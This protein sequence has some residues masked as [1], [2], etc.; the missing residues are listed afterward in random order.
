MT[1]RAG[2]TARLRCGAMEP[3]VGYESMRVELTDGVVLA[4]L[5]R[6]ERMNA[7]DGPLRRSVRRLIDEVRDNA[8]A[9]VL[10]L[11]GAGRG[12]CSGADLTAADRSHVPAAAHDPLFQWCVDLLEL[13][14]PTIAAINGVAAGGGLGMALCCDIRI[15]STDARLIPV[16]LRRAIHPDDLVTWTLPRLVGTSRALTWLYLADDIPLAEAAATGLVNDLVAP[17]ELLDRAMTLAR[18]LAAGPTMHYALTKQ[19][20]LR[21]LTREPVDAA[22]IEDWGQQRA[23]ASADFKEGIAAFKE[24]RS[25]RFEGR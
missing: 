22:M 4:T 11:T 16:W 3:F 1:G 17:E 10:V 24:K 18:R 8:E 25:P 7:F 15:C 6:P 20:V 13:P 19:A 9:R 5:D 14:K 12:F 2:A 23:F 21:N